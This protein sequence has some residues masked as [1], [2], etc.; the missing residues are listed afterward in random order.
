VSDIA[1]SILGGGWSLVAGWILPTALNVI[2]F[3][4][5]VLP[6]LRDISLAGEITRA[7]VEQRSLV[8][9]GTAVVLG[10]TLSALQVPL[11]RVLEGYLFWPRR[12]ASWSRDRQLRTKKLLAGRRDWLRLRALEVQGPPDAR[13][14]GKVHGTTE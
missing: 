2:L 12:M 8:A 9:L 13:G 4:I 5:L 1:K 14:P 3:A 11:Y 6:S 7:S 10:L